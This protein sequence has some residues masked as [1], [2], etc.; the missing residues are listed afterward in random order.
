MANFSEV[1]QMQKIPKLVGVNE[2]AEILGW[3]KQKIV[4]YISRGVFPE[5]I[6][7]LASGPIW[8]KKQIEDY[9]DSRS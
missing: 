1:I 4:T 6:Q 3:K 8:T 7:R 5:P 2:A 9:R